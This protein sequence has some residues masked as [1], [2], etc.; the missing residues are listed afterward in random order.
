LHRSRRPHLRLTSPIGCCGRGSR[1]HGRRARG[2]AHRQAGH[3]DRLAPSR[4][5][6]VLDLEN[7][8]SHRPTA[9]QQ[10]FAPGSEAVERQFALVAPRIRGGLRK[11]GISV[12]QSTVAKCMRRYPH[13]ARPETTRCRRSTYA[14]SGV[15]VWIVQLRIRS[16]L[17][18]ADHARAADLPRI[19]KL[20]KL[21]SRRTSGRR[22]AAS[23]W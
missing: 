11:P 19:H 2:P 5:P 4:P 8:P 10:R 9:R 22:P 3:S 7:P 6:P 13:S 23:T 14:P 21:P 17:H 18:D 12:S 1:E 15:N 16:R 20:S